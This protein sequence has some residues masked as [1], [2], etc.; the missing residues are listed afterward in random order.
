MKS[1]TIRKN[2]N[3]K[4][5]Q[6]DKSIQPEAVWA[7]YQYVKNG[8]GEHENAEIQEIL[9]LV[10]RDLERI[11]IARE[12]ARE[13]REKLKQERL[14]NEQ[15]SGEEHSGQAD[16][17]KS[18]TEDEKKQREEYEKYPE[19]FMFDGFM[20]FL[21]SKGGEKYRPEVMPE[22]NFFELICHFRDWVLD[23]NKIKEI[24]HLNAF[25][26]LFKMALPRL[27][28]IALRAR[29]EASAA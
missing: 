6:L 1:I 24:T 14:L 29:K 26:G 9:N 23:H 25:R 17:E 5:E 13:R 11:A 8:G 3:E 21:C 28:A 22:F 27:N 16:V 7:V 19:L 2:W 20:S 18:E 15:K 12:K 4:I 10:Q